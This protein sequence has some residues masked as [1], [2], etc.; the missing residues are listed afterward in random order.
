MRITCP[1][2]GPRPLSEFTYGGDATKTR[3]ENPEDA[4]LDTWM[5]YVYLRQ[6][7]AGQHQEHWH[8]STGCHAWL[9]VSRDTVSHELSE[10]TLALP[11]AGGDGS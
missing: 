10:V 6:N 5:D 3:P 11:R 8:H 9:V 4:G 1:W 7:P 2:C